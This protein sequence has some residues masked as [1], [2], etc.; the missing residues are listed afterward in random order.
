MEFDVSL[1]GGIRDRDCNGVGSRYG[2]NVNECEYLWRRT[3]HKCNDWAINTAPD[4]AITI[5]PFVCSSQNA[6]YFLKLS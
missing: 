3:V 2:D 4:Y 1:K 6:G 5:L